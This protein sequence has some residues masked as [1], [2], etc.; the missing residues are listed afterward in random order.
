MVRVRAIIYT[1]VSTD[2]QANSGYSLQHQK[3][4]LEQ[5]C[6]MNNIEI[7]KHYQDDFSAKTFDRPEIKKAFD[8][9]K[10]NKKD[11][12]LFLFTKWDRF[13]RNQEEAIKAIRQLH[14]FGIQ[15]NS[16][17]QPLDLENPDNKILLSMYLII[18]EV[19]NDKNS[20]RTK[21]GMRRAMKEGCFMGK[22]PVGYVHYRDENE[23]STL[24]PDGEVALLVKKAFEDF[25]TGLYS[26]NELRLLYEKKG[27]KTSPQGFMNMLRNV[28]Y[29]GKIFIPEWKK[30]PQEIVDGL[31]SKIISIE[32]F[33]KVASV[34]ANKKKI[35]I[36]IKD[37]DEL[38]PL[39]QQILCPKCGKKF[40]GA[41]SKGN[42]GVF[43][44]Y[45]CQSRCTGNHRAELVHDLFFRFL[46][47]FEIKTEICDLYL[48]ILEDKFSKD[49]SIREN[50]IR[51]IKEEIN[52]LG[53]KI[54][55]LEDSIGE[56][57]VPITRVLSIIKR[58]EAKIREL[59]EEK[60]TLSKTDRELAIYLKFG[61]SFLNGLSVYY[62]TSSSK[63]K[64]MIIGSIFPEKLIF[65]GKNY[66]TVKENVFLTLISNSNKALEGI[67]KEK[68]TLS[69]GLS[70]YAP[71]LGL[72]PR[73]L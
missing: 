25:S 69:N 1:R 12:D 29:I 54:I 27:L 20:Q 23:N 22:A 65:D 72:E 28:V 5:Y 26:A 30:E 59:K 18:P 13:S 7:V 32:V 10:N 53:D 62:E 41:A 43:Y 48:R 24:K 15:V 46:R 51:K 50:R 11:V 17:E 57:E 19:E 40:T 16:V 36:V 61:I 45:H 39:R 33:E 34:L 21:D 4:I 6:K 64:K 9:I 70:S 44:Y 2:E 58:H 52:Q 67:K 31:H 56:S 49:S 42:G 68:A 55:K 14:N 47:K 37:N 63:I 35:P 38:L 71:P 8:Y 73:T 66:R 3:A 60:E